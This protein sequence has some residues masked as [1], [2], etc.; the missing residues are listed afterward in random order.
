MN[1][2]I[3]TN[4]YRPRL[5]GVA[6]SIDTFCDEF[7]RLGHKVFI[8]AP[9]YPGHNEDKEGVFRLKSI[10]AIYDKT[11]ALPIPYSGEIAGMIPDLE[12]DI[13][14]S[15]HPFVLGQFGARLARKHKIPLVFTYHTLYEEYAHYVPFNESIVRKMAVLLST[16][17]A[18]KCNLVIVPTEG[19]RKL[20]RMNGVKTWIEKVPTGINLSGFEG[21]DPEAIR[22]EYNIPQGTK[23]LLYV[24][25]LAKEKNL[26]FL[27]EA[28]SLILKRVPQTLLLM[29][30]D[31]PLGGRLK[32]LAKRLKIED[33]IIFTGVRPRDKIYAHH[34]MADLF[35]F[36]SLTE[37][38]GLVLYE[39]IG[40]GRPVVAVEAIGTTE[41]ITNG[42]NGYLVRERTDEFSKKVVDLLLDDEE[43][44]ELS[45]GSKEMAK[46]LSSTIHAQRMLSLYQELIDQKSDLKL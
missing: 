33:H 1:I 32:R 13:I 26:T 46:A 18:N 22:R 29:V 2:G 8:F 27:I 34:L 31:G 36:S 10:P 5:S 45:I 23:T 42:V 20:L 30:G 39:A 4:N 21:V 24:G 38:Q 40:A 14:H 19:V 37:T 17:Y 9:S 15:Q 41:I 11:L 6:V 35:V 43:R 7:R 16:S 3:F 44:K 12:I 28:F 25:R